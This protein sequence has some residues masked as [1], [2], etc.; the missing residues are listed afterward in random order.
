[1]FAFCYA[2][3]DNFSDRLNNLAEKVKSEKRKPPRK[4]FDKGAASKKFKSE[5]TFNS[6]SKGN[7][8]RKNTNGTSDALIKSMYFSYL[9]IYNAAHSITRSA[10]K[11]VVLRLS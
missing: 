6:D 8:K 3:R 9:S 7:F 2:C 1:M 5:K 11:S 4:P 10:T